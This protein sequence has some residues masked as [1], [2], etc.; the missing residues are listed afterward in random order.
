MPIPLLPS[1][2]SSPLTWY[3]GLCLGLLEL[4]L[5]SPTWKGFIEVKRKVTLPRGK[6]STHDSPS[7]TTSLYSPC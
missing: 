2:S 6:A 1:P 3:L 7:I 4:A 5:I